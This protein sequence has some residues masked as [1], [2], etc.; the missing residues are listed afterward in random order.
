MMPKVGRKE[1]ISPYSHI[2]L[3]A[4]SGRSAVSSVSLHKIEMYHANNRKRGGGGGKV[5][6]GWRSHASNI[7]RRGEEGGHV[8]ENK[9]SGGEEEWMLHVSCNM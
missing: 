6:T 2:A 7:L 4:H 5:M 9:Q 8:P 1:A 3:P